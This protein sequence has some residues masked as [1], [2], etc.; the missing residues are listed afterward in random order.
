M[1]KTDKPGQQQ[2]LTSIIQQVL[3]CA[4]EN[5][6]TASEVDIGTGEGLSVTVRM[7]ELETIEHQ[8]DKGMGVT[9][10]V[11]QRK[12]SANTTD[13]SE[14]A[15]RESVEAACMIAKN[16]SEDPFAG[17]IDSKYIAG[18]SPDLDL[19]HPWSISPVDA[20]ELA[21]EC[22]SIA[23]NSDKRINNADGT[24]VNAYAGKHMYGNSHGFIDGW[25]WSSHSID[26]TVI[27][28]ENGMQRDGW[29]SKARAPEELEAIAS[30]ASKAAKR[31]VERLGAK[32][33]STRQCPVLFEAPVAIGLFG[34]F[35]GAI[36]GG[37]LYRKASFMLDKLGETVF[38]E[39]MHIYEDPYL[40][41]AMGSAPFDSDGMAT[42]KRDIV[43]NGVLQ[44]YVLSAYSARKLGLQPTGNAGGVHNLHIKP[45]EQ[46]LDSL[47]KTMHE[48]LFVTDMIGFG[49]NQV[50]GDYS[51]GASGFWV[52]NGE[53]QYPVEEITVAGN[54]LEMYQQIIAVGNDVDTRGN[55]RTGS[56]LIE[57]MTLAGE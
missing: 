3:D 44:E 47:I 11:G 33:L 2:D 56:V 39:H 9:V 52:E 57:N 20:T 12:G 45:G 48:G 14:R 5:G 53:I 18:E 27:A 37:S 36:S 42:R 16:A 6:A 7:G 1:T 34:A 29:Y 10:Y 4:R 43:S 40:P 35:V 13:F 23:R 28:E 50:T 15:I 51:R 25:D 31:T 54:L 26:C 32:K 41:R 21:L 24:M 49:V 38:A 46:N 17:L 22:E 19:Y 8:R 55:T 30:I